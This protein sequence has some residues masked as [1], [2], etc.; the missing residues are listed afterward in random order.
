MQILK[1]NI[2][3]Q[4][5]LLKKSTIRFFGSVVY[6]RF[7]F[8]YKAKIVGAETFQKLPDRNVLIISNHQTYFADV[9]FFY[10]AIYAAISGRPNTIRYPGFLRCKKHNIYY[11]AAEE[12]MK[13]GFLPK[14]LAMSG[15]VT[16]NRSWRANGQNVRRKVDRKETENIDKALQDGWLITFPQG[17][18]T[19]FAPGRIG[20]AI[21]AKRHQPIIIPVVIDGFRR[22]FDKKGL[23]TK[24]PHS[25]LKMTIKEPLQIDYSK[26]VEEI[27]HAMMTAIEQ[28]KEFN[29][30]EKIKKQES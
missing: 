5:V 3:N 25:E 13:A 10:H 28:T 1:R 23:R 20:T 8:R 2:F 4:S 18:T 6:F 15:A 16:I 7:N 19:P 17:T 12:T 9:S 14:L 22:S 24:K 11:V 26:S 30:L 27:M 29:K 21:I